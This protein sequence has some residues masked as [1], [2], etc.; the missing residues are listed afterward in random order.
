MPL[1]HVKQSTFRNE[2][3]TSFTFNTTVIIQAVTAHARV[4]FFVPFQFTE[5]FVGYVMV[6]SDFAIALQ[7]DEQRLIN[8]S[9][10]IEIMLL[11][12][13]G[14]INLLFKY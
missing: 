3:N 4:V 9:L 13:T 7:T 12:Y 5:P 6:F 10:W 2:N 8:L 14:H 11:L 1:Q